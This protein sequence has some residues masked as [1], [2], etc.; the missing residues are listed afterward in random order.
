MNMTAE[1]KL[2]K[3]EKL[4]KYY[5][6]E[7]KSKKYVDNPFIKGYSIGHF[8]GECTVAKSIMKII[9]EQ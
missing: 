2:V 8:R 9:N 7:P 1:E 3:L 6:E 5:L 4:A